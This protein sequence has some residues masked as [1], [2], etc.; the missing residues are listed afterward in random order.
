MP[1]LNMY[2]QYKTVTLIIV[3]LNKVGSGFAKQMQ[4]V[5]NLCKLLQIVANTYKL[6]QL[7]AKFLQ[8]FTTLCTIL[9]QFAQ[10]CDS[11]QTLQNFC[12]FFIACSVDHFHEKLSR[13]SC[14]GMLLNELQ[15]RNI[16][17]ENDQMNKRW[18]NFAKLFKFCKSLQTVAKFG[19]VCKLSQNCG[20]SC[21]VLQQVAKVCKC[22]HEFAKVCNTLYLLCKTTTY[23][24][25]KDNKITIGKSFHND[26]RDPS[27]KI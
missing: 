13:N 15:K 22:L 24:V 14:T 11:L 27:I 25:Q 16:S 17:C 5:A 23:L 1:S 21:K 8:N 19:K 7:V 3:L 26:F 20:K 9:R 6:L 10:F 18:K 2:F 4:S 12:K